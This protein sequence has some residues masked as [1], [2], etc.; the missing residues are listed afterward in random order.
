[1]FLLTVSVNLLKFRKIIFCEFFIFAF[2]FLLPPLSFS[3]R[4]SLL[5]QNNTSP[6]GMARSLSLSVRILTVSSTACV[7]LLSGLYF[8]CLLAI[9]ILLVTLELVHIYL[10]FATF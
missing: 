8:F 1:M 3:S 2:L 5:F 6:Y 4:V 10:L 9:R 7:L